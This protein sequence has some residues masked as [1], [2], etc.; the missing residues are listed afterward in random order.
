MDNCMFVLSATRGRYII[1]PT[2]ILILWL[3]GVAERQMQTETKT[4]V[5][6]V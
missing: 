6:P 3:A 4:S 2:P 1:S 5:E